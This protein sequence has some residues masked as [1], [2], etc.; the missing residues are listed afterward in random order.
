MTPTTLS[1]HRARVAAPRAPIQLRVLV[2]D[3]V[4]LPP[5]LLVLSR[6]PR[7]APTSFL[8][9]REGVQEGGPLLVCAARP[10]IQYP[11]SSEEDVRLQ[12]AE[13]ENVQKAARDLQLL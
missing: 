2:E 8:E 5:V 12:G 11:S 9:S 13:P 4:Q 7:R 10:V 3:R 1:E 6:R